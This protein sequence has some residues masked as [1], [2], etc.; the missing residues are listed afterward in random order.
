VGP[1]DGLLPVT[2][3]TYD[4]QDFLVSWRM[5]NGDVRAALVSPEGTVL[6][7]G[8]FVVAPDTGPPTGLSVVSDGAGHRVVLYDRTD[9]SPDYRVRRVRYRVIEGAP[10]S[11][12]PA[13]TAR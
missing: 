2:A 6:P 3:V 1:A 9:L 7:P 12:F 5:M 11:A 4:G 8:A 10:G 13:L